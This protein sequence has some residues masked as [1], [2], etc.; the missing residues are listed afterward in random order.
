VNRNTEW[1][2]RIRFSLREAL[3]HEKQDRGKGGIAFQEK[4]PNML[5]LAGTESLTAYSPGWGLRKEFI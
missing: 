2:R 5:I 4:E 3:A 1:S